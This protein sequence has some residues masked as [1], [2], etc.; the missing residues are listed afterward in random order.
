MLMKPEELLAVIDDPSVVVVDAS[1]NLTRASEGA[2]LNAF[3]FAGD[4]DGHLTCS[5]VNCS[6]GAA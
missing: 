6:R 5:A 2:H 1:I 3:R 4:G